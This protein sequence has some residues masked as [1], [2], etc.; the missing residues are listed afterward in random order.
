MG[1]LVACPLG[2]RIRRD[3][4]IAYLAL[5]GEELGAA[6]KSEF[7]DHLW[8]KSGGRVDTRAYLDHWDL[9]QP[10]LGWSA[11]GVRVLEDLGGAWA[12]LPG[13]GRRW[14]IA[15]RMTRGP[16]RSCVGWRAGGAAVQISLGDAGRAGG[17]IVFFVNGDV[18]RG[19]VLSVIPK[20]EFLLSWSRVSRSCA[21]CPTFV[22]DLVY[23]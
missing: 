10:M 16:T 18:K 22:G 13:S 2:P 6:G 20:F 1:P 14:K 3:P 9:L 4:L 11:W 5:S 21:L 8:E 23:S 15:L 12:S 19:D 7:L 17:E